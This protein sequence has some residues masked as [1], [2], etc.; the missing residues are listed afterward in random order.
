MSETKIVWKSH[1]EGDYVVVSIWERSISHQ[2]ADAEARGY[3]KG[4][5][6]KVRLCAR[7]DNYGDP[8]AL[9]EL[10]VRTYRAE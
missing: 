3:F 7:A 6:R 9:R 10:E 5:G 8:D 4:E 1:R 2:K